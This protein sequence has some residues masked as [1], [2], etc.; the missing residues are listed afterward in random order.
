VDC[1]RCREVVSADLDR[2]ATGEERRAADLHLS[3]CADCRHWAARA[4]V[5]TRRARTRVA[6]ATPDLVGLILGEQATSTTRPDDGGSA[7]DDA[8]GWRHLTLITGDGST[9]VELSA[10]GCVASCG[11]GCQQ[12]HAC[13]CGHHAA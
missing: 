13:R 2:E 8:E 12:G 1:E 4:A 10:C 6:E 11:C 5:V 9:T 7:P 3:G